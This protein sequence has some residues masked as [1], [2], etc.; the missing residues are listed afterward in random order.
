L[1]VKQDYFLASVVAAF[2]GEPRE[3]EAY[4]EGNNDPYS[5]NMET[6]LTRAH[7]TALRWNENGI[8]S[9]INGIETQDQH[10]WLGMLP[11]GD[12]NG[13]IQTFVYV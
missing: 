13:Y 9:F 11:S 5:L 4:C 6:C 10:A 12:G 7:W 3:G 2:Q 1:A 8:S